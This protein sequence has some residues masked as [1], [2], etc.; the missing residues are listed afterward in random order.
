MAKSG[1]SP[2]STGASSY[3]NNSKFKHM[4]LIAIDSGISILAL[5]HRR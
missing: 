1:P 5:S 3:E 4:F 2:G